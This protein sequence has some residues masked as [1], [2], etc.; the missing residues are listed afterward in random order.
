M[1]ECALEQRKS[2]TKACEV[3][4]GGSVVVSCLGLSLSADRTVFDTWSGAG[5]ERQMW[6]GLRHAHCIDS[7]YLSVK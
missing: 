2:E 7:F 5:M 1:D 6:F 3:V 4:L